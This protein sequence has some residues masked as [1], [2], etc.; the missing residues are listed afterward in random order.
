M[1]MTMMKNGE[2]IINF[3]Q[4]KIVRK[5]FNYYLKGKS[6]IGI[7]KELKKENIKS[8]KRK[9]KWPKRTIETILSNEKYIGSV[10]LLDSVNQE[11]YYL[12]EDNHEAII[13]EKDFNRVQR[14]KVKR[15]NVVVEEDGVKRKISKY[16][17]KN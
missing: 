14:E 15:S 5:I 11:N 12:K 2:L 16:S 7:V 10:R 8:P 1:A 9:N 17:S 6:V 3:Q 4:A 13:S